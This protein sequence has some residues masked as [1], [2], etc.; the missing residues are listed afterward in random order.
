MRPQSEIHRSCGSPGTSGPGRLAGAPAVAYLA[1]GGL[2]R[3][4][5]RAGFEIGDFTG[6][7]GDAGGGEQGN[8]RGE[9][10]RGETRRRGDAG[11]GSAATRAD[12]APRTIASSRL[13]PGPGI[14]RAD[15]A[16]AIRRERGAR[17][18]MNRHR[19]TSPAPASLPP[20]RERITKQTH[21]CSGTL[22]GAA[23]V[24]SLPQANFQTNPNLRSLGNLGNP[25]TTTGQPTS[26]TFGFRRF[27]VSVFPLASCRL[28]LA[29]SA[30][31]QTNPNLHRLGNLGKPSPTTA[32]PTSPT[33]GFRR[34][35]VSVFALASCPLPLACSGELPNKPITPP[36]FAPSRSDSRLGSAGASPSPSARHEPALSPRR[37]CLPVG[38]VPW[39]GRGGPPHA[40]RPGPAMPQLLRL[41]PSDRHVMLGIL[42]QGGGAADRRNG[43]PEPPPARALGGT[44][45]RVFETSDP[46]RV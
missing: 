28:P 25:A 18:V 35:G 9:E 13:G 23:F 10:R 24:P 32:Q 44:L 14:P 27:G 19:R 20:S 22:L 41:Q 11:T 2:I 3:R 42:A 36:T 21:C 34:F 46:Q 38:S 45:A 31:F 17:R 6:Q 37:L 29:C 7:A 12:H 39:L 33:F 1:L 16:G 43:Q 30:I 4:G 26:P 40:V 8:R 15:S 5:K